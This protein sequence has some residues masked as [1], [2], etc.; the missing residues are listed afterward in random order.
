MLPYFH[1]ETHWIGSF[2]YFEENSRSYRRFIEKFP[3]AQELCYKLTEFRH[4]MNSKPLMLLADQTIGTIDHSG[5][6]AF[7]FSFHVPGDA[8]SWYAFHYKLNAS[9]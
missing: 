7:T 3:Q 6:G 5:E 8:L 2:H 9:E 4:H 1:S